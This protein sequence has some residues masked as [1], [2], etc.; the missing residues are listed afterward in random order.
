MLPEGQYIVDD[1][2]Y[3][4]EVPEIGSQ[5]I[6]GEWLI[7]ND[8]ILLVSFGPHTSRTRTARP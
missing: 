2:R 7:P 4:V 1:V 6:A 8:G 5:E 3:F